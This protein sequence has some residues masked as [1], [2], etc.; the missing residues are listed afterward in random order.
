[1]QP[2]SNMKAV[3]VLAEHK[4]LNRLLM[5]ALN[6]ERDSIN[7]DHFGY[8]GQS[9]GIQAALSWA[10]C[11]FCDEVP[12]VEWNYRDPISAFFSMDRDLQEVA[13]KAMAIRHGFVSMTLEDRPKSEFE[14]LVEGFGEKMEKEERKKALKIVDSP[15]RRGLLGEIDEAIEKA[16]IGLPV[17]QKQLD[18]FQRRYNSGAL[19][20]ESLST[21]QEFDKLLIKL[22][23]YLGNPT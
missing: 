1:M 8:H 12:P 15:Y 17:A 2:S 14:L 23:S 3:L 22:K 21:H 11:L 20:G 10:Y 5:P 13:L 9:H 18:E 6:I 19:N 7:W 4:N 16:K